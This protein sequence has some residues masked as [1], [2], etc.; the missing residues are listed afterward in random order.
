MLLTQE[1][2]KQI[3]SEI[4]HVIK[5]INNPEVNNVFRNRWRYRV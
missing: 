2:F 1:P 3:T 5:A 4:M